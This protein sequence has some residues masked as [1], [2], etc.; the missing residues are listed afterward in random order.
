MLVPI[1]S[2]H[3]QRE[4]MERTGGPVIKLIELLSATDPTKLAVFRNECE[5]LIAEYFADNLLRQDYLM[6][7]AVKN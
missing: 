7:R 3:H 2:V 1:L 4:M 5:A 6:T